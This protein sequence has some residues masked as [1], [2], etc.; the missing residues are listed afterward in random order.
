MFL[1]WLESLSDIQ[2]PTYSAVAIYVSCQRSRRTCNFFKPSSKHILMTLRYSGG[3]VFSLDILDDEI[4]VSTNCSGYW[5]R[6]YN[7][8]K[9]ATAA[10]WMCPR[11]GYPNHNSLGCADAHTQSDAVLTCFDQT[12]RHMNLSG[13][14]RY[15]NT[16][17]ASFNW[18]IVK[19]LISRFQMLRQPHMIVLLMN[20]TVR[21]AAFFKDSDLRLVLGDKYAFFRYGSCEA[22]T[23]G[24]GSASSWHR[25]AVSGV[26]DG[27][28]SL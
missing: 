2:L 5:H 8:Q 25:S 26:L 20:I 14:R 24:S 27:K 22:S 11:I 10:K 4:W 7:Q 23:S 16:K 21:Y 9:T 12:N 18:V 6:K 28:P 1:L 13:K 15:P 17:Y 19:R 3:L